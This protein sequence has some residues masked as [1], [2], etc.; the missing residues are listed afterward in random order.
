[1][2]YFHTNLK[3]VNTFMNKERRTQN[4]VIR[5]RSDIFTRI[6]LIRGVAQYTYTH[7]LIYLVK[8]YY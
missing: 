4:Q 1:M 5:I 8:H 3:Q 6:Q 7:S 2:F